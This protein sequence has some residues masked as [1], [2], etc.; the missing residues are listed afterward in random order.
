MVAIDMVRRHIMKTHSLL[1][2]TG[3]VACA[4]LA[5]PTH[6]AR[7][8]TPVDDKGRDCIAFIESSRLQEANGGMYEH[9][10]TATNQCG[11]TIYLNVCYRGTME[12]RAITVDAGADV[13]T[14]LG[15]KFMQPYFA[16]QWSYE[17]GPPIR[18]LSD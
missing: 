9:V 16:I 11:R 8:N 3:A 14:A 5:A 13:R 12:C 2:L 1:I 18:Q 4:I 7:K 6:A 15:T 10:V 17:D